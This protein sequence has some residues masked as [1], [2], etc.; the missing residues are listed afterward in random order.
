MGSP[1]TKSKVDDKEKL[2][3]WTGPTCGEQYIFVSLRKID[4][5]QEIT[6]EETEQNICSA[7]Y[8][9]SYREPCN[10]RSLRQLLRKLI[11]R[12]DFLGVDIHIPQSFVHAVF[13][14][15]D[16]LHPV[17]ARGPERI[18]ILTELLHHQVFL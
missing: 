18:E 5:R 1:Y 17:I 10:L 14:F 4:A 12:R 6:P 16:K 11:F 15:I 13:I 8:I 2:A 3:C 7:P 9:V